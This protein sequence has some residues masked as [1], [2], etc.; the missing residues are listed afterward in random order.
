MTALCHEAACLDF[1]FHPPQN[2]KVLEYEASCSAYL[3]Y[4]V[5]RI[6]SL[7]VEIS[8][9]CVWTFKHFSENFIVHV[10][11]KNASGFYV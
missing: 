5:A 4:L 9:L 6:T 10:E 7:C 1:N 11:N 2:K 3:Y 8:V